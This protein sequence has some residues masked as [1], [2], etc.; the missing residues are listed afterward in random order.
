MQVIR[1]SVLVVFIISFYSQFAFSFGA[2][3]HRAVGQIAENHLSP[4][5]Q[6][7]IRRIMAGESL[8]IAAT[9]PDEM[10]SSPDNPKFW[11]STAAKWHF[12]NVGPDE[13]YEDSKKEAKGDAYMALNAF[14]AILK[15]EKV[16]KGPIRDGLTQYF[17]D[18]D[19]S[20]NQK[21]LQQFAVRFIVHIV[22]DIHQ[23]LHTG[24]L[25]DF[26]GNSI[27]VEWFGQP[28]K[29]HG[30]WDTDLLESQ[31][32]SYSELSDK[33]DKLDAPAVAK[34]QGSEP[35]D[36]LNES[37]VYRKQAYDVDSYDSD[38][39]YS[40]VFNNQPLLESQLQKGGLRAAALFNQI[41]K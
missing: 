20:K 17:G 19:A 7:A 6:Q 8:A 1:L 21:A 4:A 11:A 18:I 13:T 32:L 41:F 9:W 22:G 12:V 39:S 35:I 33:L 30:V 25:S 2:N 15:G 16:P 26:G 5:A 34:I 27:K 29:L 31:Q 14:V 40:Y 36:W 37:L 3:G 10:R 23:P 38:F 28:R 24:Y